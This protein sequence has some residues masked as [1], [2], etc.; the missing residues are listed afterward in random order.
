[1]NIDYTDFE[2]ILTNDCNKKNIFYDNVHLTKEGSE[3]LSDL[4]TS[5]IKHSIL[6]KNKI[7][8]KN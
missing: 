7:K 6:M 1:M 4:I 2:K 3:I 8:L 5:K